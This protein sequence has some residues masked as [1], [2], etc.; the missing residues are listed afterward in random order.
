MK[1][2][3][4]KINQQFS[5][6]LRES[7][8]MKNQTMDPEIIF[9]NVQNHYQ[10]FRTMQQQ[11]AQELLRC[12]L[13]TLSIGE[14]KWLVSPEMKMTEKV[15]GKHKYTYVE[16]LFGGY[17]CNFLKCNHCNYSSRTFDFYLDLIIQIPGF[18]KIVSTQTKPRTRAQR[19]QEAKHQKK[20]EQR[21]TRQQQQK[22][23]E[24]EERQLQ[25]AQQA[26][27]KQQEQQEQLKQHEQQEQLK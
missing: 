5:Q 16:Q 19:K 9:K 20:Q 10:R 27:L 6:F 24:Q 23:K 26:Q 3:A 25:Q 12:F 22:Q 14:E 15:K 18:R 7:R 11:D 17:L 8:Q 4:Y 2:A 1:L 21:E 13:D